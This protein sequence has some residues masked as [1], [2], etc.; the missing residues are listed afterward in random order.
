MKTKNY[1]LIKGFCYWESELSFDND[2]IWINIGYF[3]PYVA[4]KENF[5]KILA[6]SA[7]EYVNHFN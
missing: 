7:Y 3:R 1:W 4:K 2:D 5:Q 6:I